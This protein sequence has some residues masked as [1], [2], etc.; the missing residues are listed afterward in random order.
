MNKKVII[1]LAVLGILLLGTVLYFVFFSSSNDGLVVTDPSATF[2]EA[3]N[4]QGRNGSV[5]DVGVELPEAGDV[6]APR[7]V[8]ISLEPTVG[9]TVVLETVRQEV[10]QTG[11]TTATTS[12]P[13]IEVR[14]L[15][16]ASGNVYA[17]EVKARTLTRLT[18]QTLP[19]IQEASWT[20]DGSWVVTRFLTKAEGGRDTLETYVL[21]LE[22]GEAGY[23]LQDGLAD[24]FSRG[25]SS[26]VTLLTSDT[27]TVGTL[28]G[29][30]GA[31]P[32]TVFT[33]PLSSLTVHNLTSGYAAFT[34]PSAHLDGYGF[35]INSSGV[36]TRVLGPLKG[37]SLLPGSSGDTVIYSALSGRSLDLGYINTDTYE[38]V[39][40]PV[41]TLSEKCVWKKDE[42]LVYCAVP[43]T[44]SGTLPD[45]WHQGVV[46]FSDRFWRINLEERVATLIFDPST[47]A[48]VD[49]DAVSLA[50][51]EDADVLIF[52]NKKDGTLWAY[53]L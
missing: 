45:D 4:Y 44:L 2:G 26:V 6:V 11:T 46:S 12:I 1:A 17:Y 19:G 33:S 35:L 5:P 13:E 31:N 15:E 49:I 7:L 50:L 3:D 14:Y 16:K 27:G 18:N 22:E 24:A 37:L 9:G 47:I 43:K 53:D 52:T 30:D 20:D 51:D 10:S 34:K 8:R 40:L 41:N 48:D 38:R 23:F 28:A 21:P 32:Q 39:T 36:F 42:S 29:I 25:V